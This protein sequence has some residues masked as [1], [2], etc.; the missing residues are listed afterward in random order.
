MF[1]EHL[2]PGRGSQPV[3]ETLLYLAGEDWDGSVVAEINTR[4]AKNEDERLV[5]LRQAL[6]YARGHTRLESKP[7]AATPSRSRRIVTALRPGKR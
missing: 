7:K 6:D 2:L 4:K 1:D 3:A 5:M